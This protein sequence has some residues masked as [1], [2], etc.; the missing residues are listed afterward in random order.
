ML[1]KT[2]IQFLKDLKQ[3]NHRDWFEANRKVYEAAKADYLQLVGEVLKG[4]GENDGTLAI[5]QPKECVFRI[6]R[7]VRFSKDKSPYKT[8]MGAGFGKGGKKMILAGY[9]LHCEPGGS[10]IAGGM[11]MP[12]APELKKIRQEIDYCFEEFDG[13]VTS[14]SFKQQLRA[15]ENSKDMVLSRPPKGYEESNPA[16]QYLKLKSYIASAA[17]PD[18]VLTSKELVPT[19]VAAC[20]AAQPLIYFINKALE[21]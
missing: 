8:N 6:N 16:I 17:I 1:Q 9:Y 7:D 11:W 2:T 19:I 21:G 10:F 3:N 13:I 18:A 4:V 5:L 14:P 20:K 15:L 12:P